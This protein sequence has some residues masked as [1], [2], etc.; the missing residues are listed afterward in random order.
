MPSNFLPRGVFLLSCPR[1]ALEVRG[2]GPFHCPQGPDGNFLSFFA[3]ANNFP[4]PSDND[5]NV[6]HLTRFTTR[7]IIIFVLLFYLFKNF[8]RNLECQSIFNY[9]LTSFAFTYCTIASFAI[10]TVNMCNR[11]RSKGK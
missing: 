2:S 5:K 1:K 7:F 6:S 3:A 10:Q 9:I 11:M 4:L 8:T